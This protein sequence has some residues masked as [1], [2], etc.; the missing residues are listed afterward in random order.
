MAASLKVWTAA[1]IWPTS[2]LRPA[3]GTGTEV[4]PDARRRMAVVIAV[5]GLA[6]TL[7]SITAMPPASASASSRPPISTMRAVLAAATCFSP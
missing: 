7:V 3:A 4:S 2:S 1:A 6:R 5:S